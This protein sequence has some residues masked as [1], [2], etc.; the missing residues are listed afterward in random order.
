MDELNILYEQLLGMEEVEKNFL[1]KL[2]F[3]CAYF[4]KK[5]VSFN[6]LCSPVIKHMEAIRWYATGE[7]IIGL[8]ASRSDKNSFYVR[9]NTRSKNNYATTFPASLRITK[10]IGEGYYKVYKYKD[11]I[12]IKR[13]EA[14]EI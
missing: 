1:A 5:Q 14:I 6:T 9:R 12:A 2:N 13:F 3:P 10:R 7:Y 4:G 11:G 8:P